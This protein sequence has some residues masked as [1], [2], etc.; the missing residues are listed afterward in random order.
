M[1]VIPRLDVS[2]LYKQTRQ[3]SAILRAQNSDVIRAVLRNLES[4]TPKQRQK[5]KT[6]RA[7]F[8]TRRLTVRVIIDH[9]H[10][11]YKQCI[12]NT[13]SR[14]LFVKCTPEVKKACFK[15]V[16]FYCSMIPSLPDKVK[17]TECAVGQTT[18]HT[19]W[20]FASCFVRLTKL[21]NSFQHS[22]FN[23]FHRYTN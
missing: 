23:F 14:Y 15:L 3:A 6:N 19:D 12:Q 2:C 22:H 5:S 7:H 13:L 21:F 9:F 16:L 20:P 17:T 18:L 10:F 8:K 4:S 1:K 11:K